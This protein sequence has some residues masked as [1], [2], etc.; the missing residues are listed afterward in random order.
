MS[1]GTRRTSLRDTD[2]RSS[3]TYK[4]YAKNIGKLVINDV[5]IG[6]MKDGKIKWEP[7]LYLISSVTPQKYYRHRYA[8]KLTAFGDHRDDEVGC[9][10]LIKK[11]ERSADFM[12][13]SPETEWHDWRFASND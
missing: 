12:K 11:L 3:A 6:S 1:Y 5:Y 8:Y 13:N 9:I 2:Y 10:I 7:R 4:R